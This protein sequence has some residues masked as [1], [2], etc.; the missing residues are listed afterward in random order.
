MTEDDTNRSVSD[1][2]LGR[3]NDG[4]ADI[5]ATYARLMRSTIQEVDLNM[6]L[7]FGVNGPIDVNQRDW[8]VIE[9]EN[10]DDLQQFK[11]VLNKHYWKAEDYIR[12]SV[13]DFPTILNPLQ[14]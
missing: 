12:S 4:F 6:L 9:L 7:V 5:D 1:A 3:N 13:I 8:Y 14:I 11:D 10:N 2:T